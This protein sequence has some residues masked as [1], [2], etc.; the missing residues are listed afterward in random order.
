[1]KITEQA[2]GY[3]QQA[4]KDNNVNT[5]RFY[6]IAGCC[7]VNL[8]VGLQEAEENDVIEQINGVQV[9]IHPDVK[10]QLNNVTIDVEEQ[11]G[12]MGIV[13]DGYNPSSCC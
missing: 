3:I 9:A 7:G 6:G 1:M 5:L 2:K 12:E 10:D 4:M 11:D 8:G 13:L